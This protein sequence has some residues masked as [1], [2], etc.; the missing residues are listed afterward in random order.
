MGLVQMDYKA[1][2]IIAGEAIRNELPHDQMLDYVLVHSLPEN[3][4]RGN[5]FVSNVGYRLRKAGFK[6]KFAWTDPWTL[7]VEIKK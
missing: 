1:Y 3:T 6:P 7:K 2:Q 5:V 4:D